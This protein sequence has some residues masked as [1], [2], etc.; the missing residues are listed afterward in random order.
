MIRHQICQLTNSLLSP[1][2]K[3][4]FWHHM[5]LH[6]FS[7][8]NTDLSSFCEW[9]GNPLVPHGEL[10]FILK[11]ITFQETSYLMFTKIFLMPIKTDG[12]KQKRV[13]EIAQF[14]QIKRKK[15]KNFIFGNV[16]QERTC[17]SLNESAN[18]FP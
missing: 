5:S 16:M 17:Q 4:V 6:N 9:V 8:D 14:S 12:G 1:K 15:I 10:L 11:K 3:H 18:S 13:E 7:G 2:E